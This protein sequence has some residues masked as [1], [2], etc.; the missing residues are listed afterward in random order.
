MPQAQVNAA[1]KPNK[2]FTV[3]IYAV[4]FLIAL[5]TIPVLVLLTES[6][7]WT[8]GIEAVAFLLAGFVMGCLKKSIPAAEVGVALIVTLWGAFELVKLSP[9]W[10]GWLLVVAMVV[11]ALI[12]GMAGGFLGASARGFKAENLTA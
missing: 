12:L 8:L 11:L 1:P 6:L 7:W 9:D 10:L 3:L 2:L 4:G 5:C